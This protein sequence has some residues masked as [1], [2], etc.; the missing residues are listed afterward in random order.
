MHQSPPTNDARSPQNG[1]ANKPNATMREKFVQFGQSAHT[2]WSMGSA[3]IR[4]KFANRTPNTLPLTLKEKLAKSFGWFIAAVFAVGLV[5]GGGHQRNSTY[6]GEPLSEQLMRLNAKYSPFT[7][8]LG[9]KA[10]LPAG[11]H[12]ATPDEK[13]AVSAAIDRVQ[14]EARPN[15]RQLYAFNPQLV[16]DKKAPQHF[17][18]LIFITPP[19]SAWQMNSA[20][21][22][23]CLEDETAKTVQTFT[24]DFSRSAMGPASD[25]KTEPG[26]ASCAEIL[27][28]L[29][30]KAW[31]Q[32]ARDITRMRATPS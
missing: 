10:T 23:G 4:S 11:L 18:Q 3:Y 26:A 28:T 21:G 15:A 5:P 24:V 31:G 29:S 16:D 8:R 19:T 27:G 32:T 30:Q 6:A 22:F 17:S 9:S 12:Y 2:V 1:H 14:D 25:M 7:T 20:I 13:K